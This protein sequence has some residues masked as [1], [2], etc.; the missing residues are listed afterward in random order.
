MPPPCLLLLSIAFVV[1]IAPSGASLYPIID[2]RELPS[3]GVFAMAYVN[4]NGSNNMMY[5]GNRLQKL[6]TNNYDLEKYTI[7]LG[8]NASLIN[9]DCTVS[10]LN[11]WWILLCSETTNYFSTSSSIGDCPSAYRTALVEQ[12]FPGPRAEFRKGNATFYYRYRA[13][14]VPRCNFVNLS[15]IPSLVT[16]GCEPFEDARL[17]AASEANSIMVLS[18]A[19]V[20]LFSVGTLLM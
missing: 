9:G 5:I 17:L 18:L 12:G 13:F 14:R 6:R 4:V 2:C 15:V 7:K 3:S 20:L 19:L 11:A 10:N 1:A 8:E 16:D